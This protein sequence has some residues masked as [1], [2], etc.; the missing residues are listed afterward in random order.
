VRRTAVP[1]Q[2][3]K[4]RVSAELNNLCWPVSD[5]YGLTE[6]PGFLERTTWQSELDYWTDWMEKRIAWLDEQFRRDS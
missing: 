6:P 4:I 3:G 1:A 2:I 5:R